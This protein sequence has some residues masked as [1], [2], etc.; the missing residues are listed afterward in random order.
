M[1][2][3][4]AGLLLVKLDIPVKDSPQTP[5]TPISPETVS[6]SAKVLG[7]EKTESYHQPVL[8]TAGFAGVWRT[9]QNHGPHRDVIAFKP[10]SSEEAKAFLSQISQQLPPRVIKLSSETPRSSRTVKWEGRLADMPCHGCHGPLGGGAHNGSVPGKS[11]CTLPHHPSCHGG[12][13]EDAN[14][15]ACPIGYFPGFDQTMHTQDFIPTQPQHGGMPE[16][17]L[18]PQLYPSLVQ[19]LHSTP[20][21]GGQPAHF[22]SEEVQRQ[23]DSHRAS[24]Q[25]QAVNQDRPDNYDITIANL[26]SDPSRRE[27]VENQMAGLRDEIPA[28]FAAPSANVLSSAGVA[29]A[30]PPEVIPTVSTSAPPH[31]APASSTPAPA[32]AGPG[33]SHSSIGTSVPIL[34]N[35]HTAPIMSVATSTP[36][37]NNQYAA[38]QQNHLP[39]QAGITTSVPQPTGQQTHNPQPFGNS[40]QGIFPPQPQ[41]GVPLQPSGGGGPPSYGSVPLPPHAV[42]QSTGFILHQQTPNPANNVGQYQYPQPGQN[43][44]TTYSSQQQ[45]SQYGYGFQ[46]S[47]Q[48]QH[49]FQNLPVQSSFYGIGLSQ[50]NHTA[51]AISGILPQPCQTPYPPLLNQAGTGQPLHTPHPGPGQTPLASAQPPQLAMQQQPYNHPSAQPASSHAGQQAFQHWPASFP[52]PGFSAPPQPGFSAPPQQGFSAT[53]QPHQQLPQNLAGQHAQYSAGQSGGQAG[54][55]M[56]Y[57]VGQPGAPQAAQAQ[58]GGNRNFNAG[59]VG[60]GGRHDLPIMSAPPPGATAFTPVFDYYVDSTGQA[61]KVLRQPACTPPTRTEF[62]CSPGSGRVYTVQ[63]PVQQSTTPK[64]KTYEW[65]CNPRTGERYQ[66]ESSSVHVQ[67]SGGQF[68]QP[69]GQQGQL[70]ALPWSAPGPAPQQANLLQQN[71]H[72][73]PQAQQSPVGFD[74]QL[75]NKVSGIVKLCE[76]EVTKKALKPLDFA[77]KASAKWAKKITS[78]TVN[79]PLFIFGAVSELESAMSGRSEPLSEVVFLAKLRHLRNVLDVCCLNS[80]SADFKGYG[81]TIAKDYALKVE[82]GIEQQLT[83]WQDV[84]GGIQTSQLLLAQ[85]DFPKPQ[86]SVKSGITETKEK[87]TAARA[88]CTTYNTCKS[89]DKCEYEVSHPDKKCVLKHEC[90]WCKEKLKQSWRHQEWNCKKKN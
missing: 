55:P 36:L 61:C 13:Q 90:S 37:P 20:Q 50:P 71:F 1:H 35:S 87:Q 15:R 75:Q 69:H 65:R 28:L 48:S 63:V 85:M 27:V 5:A 89:D 70:P 53:P 77:K 88:R 21:P 16:V 10:S 30:A 31:G 3:T 74:Q 19:P 12:V 34:Q 33:T 22:V 23:M 86:K 9:K 66:V 32:A 47:Q 78:E 81:W 43:A 76:G 39:P 73:Q 82:M 54:Q 44:Q 68:L 26:R 52:Q 57:S 17:A 11:G 8:S 18:P 46:A 49:G 67:A 38:Q 56:Q 7:Q 51:P 41:G 60:Q 29:S 79:L 72:P 45:P 62:R 58:A 42:P 2:H 25:A 4:G 59:N 40:V 83:T 6:R 80:D 64:A 14:Y 24:N 84:S